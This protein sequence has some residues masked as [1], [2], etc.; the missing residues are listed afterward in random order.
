MMPEPAKFWNNVAE[1]YAGSKVRDVR[2]YEKKLKIT[3]DLFP[4]NAKVLEIACGTGTTALHHAP[5]VEHY[6]AT[7][8]SSAML[9]IARRKANDQGVTNITFSEQE[10]GKVNWPPAQYDMVLAMSILHLLPDRPTALAKIHETLKPGG[11]LISS[12]VCLGNMAFF[13]PLLIGAMKLLGKAPKVVDILTHEDLAS[14][15]AE[16][17]FEVEDHHRMSKEKVAFVVARKPE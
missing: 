2:A 5:C 9:E 10:V 13:F 7:D 6:M 11:R 1:G 17:G 3:R 4:P 16:A 14:T 12:T 8:I 15:I